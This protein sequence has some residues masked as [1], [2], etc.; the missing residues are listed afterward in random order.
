[1]D[2][3]TVVSFLAASLFFFLSLSFFFQKDTSLTH[4]TRAATGLHKQAWGKP[5][6]RHTGT[7]HSSEIGRLDD[8]DEQYFESGDDSADVLTY[9]C[10]EGVGKVMKALLMTRSF[11]FMNNLVIQEEYDRIRTMLDSTDLDGER[12]FVVTGHPGIGT[13]RNLFRFSY[14]LISR[15]GKTTFLI[16][17]LLSRLG[18][19][20]PTAFQLCNGH[21]LIFDKDGVHLRHIDDHDPRLKDCWA[22]SDSDDVVRS[23]CIPFQNMAQ[24]VIQTTSPRPD[25]WKQWQKYCNATIIISDLPKVLEVG[26]VLRELNLDTARTLPLVGKWGPSIRTITNIIRIPSLLGDYEVAVSKASIEMR[27][28]RYLSA[29]LSSDAGHLPSSECS[30]ILFIRPQRCSTGINPFVAE[31]IIP[32]K[33]LSSGFPAHEVLNMLTRPNTLSRRLA[34]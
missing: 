13:S 10:L 30:A 6:P 16:Y 32:T 33:Y 19:K 1:M 23:P 8:D 5:W 4:V 26:A 27:S 3:P 28:S 14:L 11:M 25:R 15:L 12:A 21:Y 29:Y 7:I 22:L 17:L 31:F 20:L 9:T 2:F 34:A 18:R 24:R